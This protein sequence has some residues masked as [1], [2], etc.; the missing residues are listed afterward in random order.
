MAVL[1]DNHEL[2]AAT[3][4]MTENIDILSMLMDFRSVRYPICRLITLGY[5]KIA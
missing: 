2:V 5:W 4:S 3:Q 1:I